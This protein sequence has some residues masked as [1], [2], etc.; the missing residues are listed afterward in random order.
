MDTPSINYPNYV[1]FV[2][3]LWSL[4]EVTVMQ[5]QY[6]IIKSLATYLK[7]DVNEDKEVS[8]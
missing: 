4:F 5:M 8:R 1:T 2:Q 7:I 6:M 3:R